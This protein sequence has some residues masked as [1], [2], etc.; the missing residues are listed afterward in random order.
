[1]SDESNERLFERQIGGS[2]PCQRRRI[3]ANVNDFNDTVWLDAIEKVNECS[4]NI[5]ESLNVCQNEKS[6]SS[7]DVCAN[8]CSKKSSKSI[9]TDCHSRQFQDCVEEPKP[10]CKKCSHPKTR[11]SFEHG[12]LK[13]VYTAIEDLYG[14]AKEHRSQHQCPHCGQFKQSMMEMCD[15]CETNRKKSRDMCSED[16]KIGDDCVD[17]TPCSS[18][19][20][21]L[22][23]TS[24]SQKESTCSFD[25]ISDLSKQIEGI[26]VAINSNRCSSKEKHSEHS[27]SRRSKS[28]TIQNSESCAPQLSPKEQYCNR[29]ER[30]TDVNLEE[31]KENKEV[32]KDTIACC[33][34]KIKDRTKITKDLESK[35]KNACYDIC[36][37]PSYTKLQDCAVK[38]DSCANVDS[39]LKSPSASDVLHTLNRICDILIKHEGNMKVSA[40]LVKCDGSLEFKKNSF[41]ES[42][43]SQNLSRSSICNS[44]PS[45]KESDEFT[46]P[47]TRLSVSILEEREQVITENQQNNEPEE[48]TCG[49]DTGRK[50]ERTTSFHS[51]Y[52]EG[53][54][55]GSS[56]VPFSVGSPS[57]CFPCIP[58]FTMPICG[59]SL[60]C[61][62]FM[63]CPQEVR[64]CP[65]N[66]ENRKCEHRSS[67]DTKDDRVVCSKNKLIILCINQ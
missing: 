40:S 36:V 46:T 47:K 8:P 53:K 29:K 54:Q 43:E 17:K 10:L 9:Y 19:T 13:D 64:N 62:P 63:L 6:L 7:K 21:T 16:P 31:L 28:S 61:W 12:K 23:E 5:C 34:T 26:C 45:G 41:C 56:E 57:C 2:N 51:K 24:F 4:R 50:T 15:P 1:M 49:T 65:Y 58:I 42:N 30:V 52:C 38:N 3:H 39:N 59:D 25:D 44:D 22:A 60:K 20:K 35:Q 11:R 18:K 33:D 32:E 27:T 48:N 37:E 66:D 55:T 14:M 67:S